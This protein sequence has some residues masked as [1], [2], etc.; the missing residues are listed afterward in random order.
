MVDGI[1]TLVTCMVEGFKHV[2]HGRPPA[3]KDDMN[4]GLE[5]EIKSVETIKNM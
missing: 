1:Q 3:Y 2:L 5:G 4:K